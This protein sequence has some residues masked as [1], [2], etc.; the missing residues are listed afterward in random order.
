MVFRPNGRYIILKDCV[1]VI[2]VIDTIGSYASIW[3]CLSLCFVFAEWDY[4]IKY[5][6]SFSFRLDVP[7]QTFAFLTLYFLYIIIDQIRL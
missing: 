5:N 7:T 1:L 3:F 4:P 6:N 2:I